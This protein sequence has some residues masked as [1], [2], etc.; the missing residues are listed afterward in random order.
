MNAV[1]YHA[2]ED[3]RYASIPALFYTSDR[4]VATLGPVVVMLVAQVVLDDSAEQRPETRAVGN[5]EARPIGEDVDDGVL[6][7]VDGLLLAAQSRS[8]PPAHERLDPG[9]IALD[10]HVECSAFAGVP[11]PQQIRRLLR[12]R[13]W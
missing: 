4:D 10:E 11:S 2:P 6:H 8:E 12:V 1:I 7:H 9:E 3:V 5:D 13:L